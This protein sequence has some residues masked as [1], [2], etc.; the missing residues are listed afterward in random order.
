MPAQPP[1]TRLLARYRNDDGST[2]DGRDGRRDDTA[3]LRR[4]LSAGPGT[5]CLGPGY[6]RFGDVAI[7]TGVTIAGAGSGTIVRSNGAK[8]IFRP[9]GTHGW[10][11]RDLALDGEAAGK[12]E[13]RA[14]EGCAGLDVEGCWGYAVRD[15][16]ARDFRGAGVRIARTDLAG[17]GWSDGGSLDRVVATGNAV[18]I[19]FALRGEYVNATGLSGSR[20]V[21]GCLINAGNA[22]VVA[23]NFGANLDGIVI[24]DLENGS[25]GLIAGCM[26]NHN[27][28]HALRATGARYGMNVTGC[29]FFYGTILLEDSAGINITGGSISCNVVTRG[30]SASRLAGNYLLPETFTFTLAPSTLVEGNFTEKGAWEENRVVKDEG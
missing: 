2:P 20:N 27:A 4:A 22:K 15:V 24:E 5:V 9:R 16:Q 7:P 28:R 18:G 17:A 21:V 19:H 8:A 14:D 6:Y 25:H 23:S 1:A 13:E 10:G 12:W 11:L 29:C 30:D 26:V 3:A